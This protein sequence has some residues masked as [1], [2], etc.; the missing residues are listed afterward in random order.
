[1]QQSGHS[2]SKPNHQRQMK[3]KES[4]FLLQSAR[5]GS[6]A[7]GTAHYGRNIKVFGRNTRVSKDLESKTQRDLG[8]SRVP[9]AQ[10]PRA[11]CAADA[12]A[13]GGGGRAGGE[14]DTQAE[15]GLTHGA[16]S[17]GTISCAALVG[18]ARDSAPGPPSTGVPQPAKGTGTGRH[19][20]PQPPSVSVSR[21]PAA[22]RGCF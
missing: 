2:L 15:K 12:P 20:R 5:T 4:G 14:P 7:F 19:E 1:M 13:A 21:E 8:R 17:A 22:A 16:R 18:P 10:Q 3:K 9:R 11:P 6:D